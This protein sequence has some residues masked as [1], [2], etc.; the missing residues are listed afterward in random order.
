LK[1][2]NL[3]LEE[4]IEK[5]LNNR[6]EPEMD[7]KAWKPTNGRRWENLNIRE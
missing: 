7:Y 2:W 6:P 5:V 1:R 3:K 4:K